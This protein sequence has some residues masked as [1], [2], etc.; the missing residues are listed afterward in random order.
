VLVNDVNQFCEQK[1]LL[2]IHPYTGASKDAPTV[3]LGKLGFY[4]LFGGLSI[5]W[6]ADLHFVATCA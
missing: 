3:S 1:K 6:E 4:N 5:V 2:G